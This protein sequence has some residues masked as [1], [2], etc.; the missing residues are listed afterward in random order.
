MASLATLTDQP[1]PGVASIAEDVPPLGQTA[2]M[3]VATANSVD[4]T[5]VDANT[6]GGLI[7]ITDGA[8]T[9]RHLSP[10]S[11]STFRQCPQRWKYRYIER[12]PDPAGIPA[13]VGTFVH[14]I[15]EELMVAD[16]S[17]R[18]LELAKSHARDLWPEV[19][20]DPDFQALELDDEEQ[21]GVRWKSW[22]LVEAYFAMEDPTEV[23]V[24]ER[25]QRLEVD[26][27]G[28]PFVG[29][30]DRV[31]HSDDGLLVTDYKT[32]KAPASKYV[33][34]RLDQV[35]L[36]AAALKEIG[37]SVDR[38]RLMYIGTESIERSLDPEAVVAAVDGHRSTWDSIGSA[39]ERD[40][41]PTQT[42]PLCAWCPYV[43]QCAAGKVEVE[44]RYG[45]PAEPAG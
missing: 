10:S 6:N 28:V 20:D 43:G 5:S 15:L 25:E 18:T 33:D 38:V 12:L 9:V 32:G 41:F 23:V 42:G 37:Q 26:L 16:P 44:R 7:V 29:V 36:Y 34:G 11:A 30:V 14:R 17:E 40:N 1:T 3:T 35:W 2:D 19:N 4:T 24:A 45:P 22:R 31:D 21:R 8:P 39:M 27:A 13:L